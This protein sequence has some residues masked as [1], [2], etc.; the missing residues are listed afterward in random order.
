ML[1]ACQPSTSN[2]AELGR[3][4]AGLEQ[5]PL[6]ISSG[7]ATHR[8]TVEVART[9]E[10]QAYGLMN[11]NEL[12]SDQGMIFPFAQVRQASF[13]M[14]DTLIPLDIIFIRADGTIANIENAVPLSLD[15]VMSLGP[16]AAVLEIPGGRSAELGIKP[17]DKVTW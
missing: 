17:G 3:S 9:E 8:F 14:K 15:Q 12:A 1:P 10:E 16:V 2:A 6:T 4:A 5:L 13:W 11:R 7:G